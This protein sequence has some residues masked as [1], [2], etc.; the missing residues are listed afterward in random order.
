MQ[1]VSAQVVHLVDVDGSG[2]DR[3]NESQGGRVGSSDQYIEHF[4]GFDLPVSLQHIGQWSSGL[5]EFGGEGFVRRQSWQLHVFDRVT[6]GPVTEVV[7]Q[8]RD[9]QDFG[10]VEIDGF[11][12]PGITS[13]LPDIPQRV[14]EDTQRVLEACV[15]GSGIN[16]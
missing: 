13:Q 16:L 2:E 7:Q 12:E 9:E 8:G 3:A 15:S 5:E 1:A 4:F 10:G 6:E 11:A 14:V